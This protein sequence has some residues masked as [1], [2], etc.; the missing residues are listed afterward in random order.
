MHSVVPEAERSSCYIC[1]TAGIEPN[2][3]LPYGLHVG[4]L[5]AEPCHTN[6]TA[7]T[8]DY[9]L[10]IKDIV[11]RVVQVLI[12]TCVVLAQACPSNAALCRCGV[13]SLICDTVVC[14]S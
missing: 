6:I 5:M 1:A 10:C 8:A 14:T 2:D 12:W 7:D 13:K 11:S 4:E 3:R 9:V